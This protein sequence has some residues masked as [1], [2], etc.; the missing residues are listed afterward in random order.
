M[1]YYSWSSDPNKQVIIPWMEPDLPG[2]NEDQKRDIDIETIYINMEVGNLV[3][4][5]KEALSFQKII[6]TRS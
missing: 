5:P 4:R 6:I 1:H 2:N 3:S